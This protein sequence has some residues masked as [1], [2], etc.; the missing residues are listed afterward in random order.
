MQTQVCGSW[1]LQACPASPWAPPCFGKRQNGRSTYHML[2]Y[3]T[4][5]L[6]VCRPPKRARPHPWRRR[7]PPGGGTWP[8]GPGCAAA[9][10]RLAACHL[11]SSAPSPGEGMVSRWPTLLQYCTVAFAARMRCADSSTQHD[12][13]CTSSLHDMAGLT[14][15]PPA[16]VSCE[17]QPRHWCAVTGLTGKPSS[18]SSIAGCSTCGS[19][20]HPL[21]A[22]SGS[23]AHHTPD[24]KTAAGVLQ[25]V[26]AH[27]MSPSADNL[28]C[29]NHHLSCCCE[30]WCA[31][32]CC[33]LPT[34]RTLA[35]GAASRHI[36]ML[37]HACDSGS[38]PHCCTASSQAAA[39]PGTVT[40]TAW[41]GGS[42]AP[43]TPSLRTCL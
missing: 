31:G 36:W 29:Y 9:G 40:V 26:T 20:R 13:V 2:P 33:C 24:T 32:E 35:Q 3:F 37:A 12:D 4:P 30:A 21:F 39:A 25:A 18:A 5:M 1:A 17:K 43:R 27:D 8:P 42:A 16:R 11:P 19:A 23:C 28:G 7:A 41:K 10:P 34:V 14:P 22:V 38:V 15:G 6:V